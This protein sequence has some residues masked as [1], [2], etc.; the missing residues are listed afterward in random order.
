[1][2]GDERLREEQTSADER[3]REEYVAAETIAPPRVS[4]SSALTRVVASVVLG[5]VLVGAL[6][7]FLAPGVQVVIALAKNGDRVRGYVGED[8]DHLF[9]A[10]TIMAGLLT[11]LALTSAAAVWRWQEHRGPEM[12]G[13]LT[14]GLLLAAAAATGVGAGIAGLRFDAVDVASA[15]VT[16]ERRVFY[17]TEAPGVFFGHSPWQIAATIVLPAGIA[18]LVYAIGALSTARD[19]LGAWP[20][21]IRHAAPVSGRAPTADGVPPVAPS[22]P[23][24]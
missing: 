5:G 1:M 23:S 13:A 10:A 21:A 24:R 7:A 9:L 16:P 11:I 20:P 4:R 22:E 19:D 17:V 2:N 18:A 14:V 15:P 6:W 3:L 8:S 12:V